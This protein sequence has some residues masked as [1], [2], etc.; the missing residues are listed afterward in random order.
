MATNNS[1]D[2]RSVLL[3]CRRRRVRSFST[4]EYGELYARTIAGLSNA[5]CSNSCSMPAR[6]I[7]STRC[8]KLCPCVRILKN[9]LGSMSRKVFF[10]D[11][12]FQVVKRNRMNLF[13]NCSRVVISFSVK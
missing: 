10:S 1:H 7:Y 12:F 6:E 9:S 13:F 11:V 4:P 3:R 8:G 2:P 5:W